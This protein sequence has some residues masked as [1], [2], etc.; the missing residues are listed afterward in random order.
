MVGS[1]DV[2]IT[3]IVNSFTRGET[4]IISTNVPY[5]SPSIIYSIMFIMLNRRQKPINKTLMGCLEILWD[6]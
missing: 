2:R 1:M 4:L 5:L 6:T 3:R